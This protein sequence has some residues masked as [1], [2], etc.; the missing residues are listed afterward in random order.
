M[1]Y[2][3]ERDGVSLGT[4][5]DHELVEAL[6]NGQLKLSDLGWT[7]GMEDWA[8]LSHL[9]EIEEIAPAPAAAVS[10]IGAIPLPTITTQGQMGKVMPM[11]LA[12]SALATASLV[13]GVAAL[14]AGCFTGVAAIV[15][16]V[17]ALQRIE[18]SGGTLGGRGLAIAGLVMGPVFMLVGMAVQGTVIM[19]MLGE[20]ADNA[21]QMKAM[22]NARKIALAMQVYAADHGGAYPDTDKHAPPQTSND[23]CRLLIKAGTL[24]DES[25]FT[26]PDSPYAGDGIVGDHPY[27]ASALSA[28]ENH[29]AMVKGVTDSSPGRAPLIFENPLPEASWPPTWS[30]ADA[31]KPVPGRAW[32][33]GKIIIARRDSSV[34]A[35]QL[36]ADEGVHVGLHPSP[37][38]TDAFTSFNPKGGYLDVQR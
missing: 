30:M 27:F 8:P 6:Y 37:D 17:M 34:N 5:P 18:R 33:S 16:G 15:L 38:G 7:D 1:I 13:C 32:R 29:W 22:R 36:A 11:K 9:V 4:L 10:R 2:H 19:P 20:Y 24:E 28:G 26:A 3:L 21:Q 14:V 12:T 35:E 25:V 31:G 23:A